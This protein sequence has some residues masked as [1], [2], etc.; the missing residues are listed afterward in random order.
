MNN[1]IY[2]V[3]Y[4]QKDEYFDF[5]EKKITFYKENDVVDFISTFVSD[6]ILKRIFSFN[7][8]GENLQKHSVVFD[9]RLKLEVIKEKVTNQFD[10]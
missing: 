3:V 6:R 4:D 2:I 8:Y 10:I 5:E 7:E 1:R 9:G